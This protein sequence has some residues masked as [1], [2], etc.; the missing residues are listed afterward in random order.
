MKPV[1]MAL[2]FQTPVAVFRF[3][4][5]LQTTI[6]SKEDQINVILFQLNLIYCLWLLHYALPPQ[7]IWN[8]CI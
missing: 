2:I 8:K 4:I 5:S 1:S 7:T 6:I 3:L